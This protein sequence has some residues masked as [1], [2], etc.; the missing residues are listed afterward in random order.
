MIEVPLTKAQIAMV[1]DQD[2]WVL[3]FKWYAHKS[4]HDK[5]YYAVRHSSDKQI[6]MA[7]E[8]MGEPEGLVVDHINHDTLDNRRE[9][10][11]VVTHADNMHNSG[12]N[13]NNASGYR[14][15]K[16]HQ[17]YWRA[18][19][20]HKSYGTHMTESKSLRKFLGLFDTAEDAARA[21]DAEKFRL[22]GS[23]LG[24]NFPKEYK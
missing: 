11:R 12:L 18:D 15:V 5:T 9:N 24:L 19:L 21:Y 4:T 10:L 22:T 14:G 7:R 1:D 13:I 3:D 23:T 8:I 2:A 16:K 6:S 17:K 20:A